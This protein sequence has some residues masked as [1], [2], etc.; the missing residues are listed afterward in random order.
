MIIDRNNIDQYVERFFDGKT[1]RQ[2]EEAIYHYFATER[3]PRHLRRYK[4]IMH[5]F[6]PSSLFVF[7]FSKQLLSLATRIPN[8]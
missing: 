2:E 5:G 6:A 8:I 7:R 4:T 1:N 3:I